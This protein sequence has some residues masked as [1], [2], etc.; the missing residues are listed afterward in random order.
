M[1]ASGCAPSTLWSTK[2]ET[3]DGELTRPAAAPTMLPI[4]DRQAPGLSTYDAK[5]PATTFAPIEPLLPP[6]GAPNV[7]IVLL[8]DVGF[9][10]SSTFGGPCHRRRRTGW[11]RVVCATTGSTP[12]RCARRPVP[13]CCRAA[14]TIRSG[15][16]RSRRRRR[17][18]RETVRCGNTK[19]PL[20][21]TLKLN[22]YS[23]AQF[24]K[25]HEVPVWQ[26]SPMGPFDSWPS[27]GGGFDDV[28][29]VHRW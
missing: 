12:R 15:W 3:R 18:R 5:D 20:A 7:L 26:S 27:G 8:D 4:P 19:A 10:A 1:S 13:R 23:T 28:L 6:V 21:M 29:R 14:T 25:C 9:G 16:A 24:G 2:T 17:R 11:R 22:G